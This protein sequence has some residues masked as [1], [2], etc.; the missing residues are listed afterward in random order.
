M[1]WPMT[2][3]LLVSMALL[4]VL[5][6]A[7]K[8]KDGGDD[9][10]SAVAPDVVDKE[11]AGLDPKWPTISLNGELMSVRWS[12]GDSFKFKSGPHE[13]KGVRL[14]GYNTLESYGPVHRWGDWSAVE[15]YFI[16]KSSWR[17]GASKSWNCTTD[18]SADGYGRLLVNC[19][20]AAEYIISEGHGTVFGI[21]EEPSKALL[22]AQKVAIK[23]GVGMWE[24][25]APR[26]MITSLHSADEDGE[27]KVTYNRVVDTR[28]GMSRQA[29]HKQ[30][31]ATCEEVCMGGDE[32]SCMVYVPFSNRYKNKAECLI[33]RE[34]K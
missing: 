15:L 8:K 3:T 32:G 1:L 16:A 18:G 24:K 26:E 30:T 28:T 7:C 11:A 27:K 12:D 19:P 17:L 34:K 13:G 5:A 25:G 20:D 4:L 31:Y 29:E 14:M 33:V 10:G 6:P 2:R 23:K 22:Q 21:D 9:S